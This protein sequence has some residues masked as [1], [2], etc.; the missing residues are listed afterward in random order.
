MNA[1]KKSGVNRRLNT[2][3][4]R[5]ELKMYRRL[6]KMWTMATFFSAASVMF[7]PP[8]S[9]PRPGPFTARSRL[10]RR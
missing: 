4:L 8:A 10:P 5:S 6:R 1:V 2:F 3:R 7:G 9:P